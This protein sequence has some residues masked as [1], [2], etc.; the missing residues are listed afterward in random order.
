[1]TAQA[2]LR[3]LETGLAPLG[4]F[5]ARAMF[6]GHGLYLDD[7]MFGLIYEDRLFLKLDEESRPAFERAESKAFVYSTKEG[8]RTSTSYWLCPPAAL[9]DPVPRVR[10]DAVRSLGQMGATAKDVL[11]SVRAAAADPDPDVRTAA[12]RAARLIDPRTA[13]GK[14]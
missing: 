12:T 3:R 5:R 6:G 7:L 8:R 4:V 9:K 10:R 13:G 11:P 2:I 14:P 1:M